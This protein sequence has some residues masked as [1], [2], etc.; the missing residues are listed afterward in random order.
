[1]QEYIGYRGYRL[2]SARLEKGGARWFTLKVSKL[3][4][5][6]SP[7]MLEKS[8]KEEIV[9][10]VKRITDARSVRKNNNPIVHHVDAAGRS[11]RQR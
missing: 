8:P 9:T 2:W 3:L 7:V 1:M 6:N 11:V 5:L 4:C 10:G